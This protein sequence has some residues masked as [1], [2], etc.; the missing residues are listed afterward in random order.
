MKI[1]DR[2]PNGVAKIAVVWILS[3]YLI[4]ATTIL[5]MFLIHIKAFQTGHLSRWEKDQAWNAWL[6]HLCV[7]IAI[8]SIIMGVGAYVISVKSRKWVK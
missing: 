5:A 4:Q 1:T 2:F 7:T 8:E 6:I 3:M